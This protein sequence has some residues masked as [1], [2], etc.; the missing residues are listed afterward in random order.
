MQDFFLFIKKYVLALH[1]NIKFF[2]TF[3]LRVLKS[4]LLD[5]MGG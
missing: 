2:L 4:I 5:F 3:F 1:K